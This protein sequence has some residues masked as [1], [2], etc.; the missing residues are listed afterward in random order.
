MAL[1]GRVIVTGMGKS[2]HIA[3]K[4]AATL[5]STGTPAYFVHPAEASHGDLGMVMRNDAVLALSSSGDTEE[6]VDIVTYTRRHKIL[7]IAMTAHADS[8][9]AIQADKL[10]LMPKVEEACPM[11]LAPTSSTTSALVYGDA[12]AITL[13]ERRNFTAKQFHKFHPGGK[14]GQK[15]IRV[16]SIMHKGEALPIVELDST[17]RDAIIEANSKRLGSAIVCDKNKKAHGIITDGDLRRWMIENKSS[18]KTFETDVETVMSKNI[19][20]IEQNKLVA[21]GI[22]IMNANNITA[23]VVLDKNKQVVGLLHLQ[24]CLRAGQA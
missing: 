9:L 24:D 11:G 21:E 17:M 15:L 12:L 20:T 8:S 2:G 3:R 18:T 1:K 16:E 13:L 22:E 14:L 6:L 4:I 19:R 23:L 5:A 10:L 7:L